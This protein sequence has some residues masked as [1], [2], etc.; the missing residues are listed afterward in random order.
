MPPIFPPKGPRDDARWQRASDEDREYGL[1]CLEF[2]SDILE[3]RPEHY[4]ALETAAGYFTHLGYYADG[5]AL[6]ERLIAIGPKNPAV[7]YNLACSLSLVGRRD[8][9][10]TILSLAVRLGYAD[11]R[12]A[13]RDGDLA[14]IRDDA[15]F[16]ALLRRMREAGG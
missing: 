12:H 7:L 1:F 6:D 2:C 11:H 15:R 3:R 13:A 5:L 4:E 8:D 9:S 14:G 16:P 10:L